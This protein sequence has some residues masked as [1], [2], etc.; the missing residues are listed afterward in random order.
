MTIVASCCLI[1]RIFHFLRMYETK[2]TLLVPLRWAYPPVFRLLLPSGFCFPVWL[3]LRR[4]SYGLCLRLSVLA[5]RSGPVWRGQ[6]APAGLIWA[7]VAFCTRRPPAQG[8]S[9]AVRQL[10]HYPSGSS[11]GRFCVIFS[12][13]KGLS[14]VLTIGEAFLWFVF[15]FDCRPPSLSPFGGHGLRRLHGPSA[16]RH[17]IVVLETHVTVVFQSEHVVLGIDFVVWAWLHQNCSAPS[18]PAFALFLSLF[19]RVRHVC[20]CTSWST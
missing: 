1:L 8:F 4:Y 2:C 10:P 11:I 7:I 20:R 15:A 14:S 6:A 17:A 18:V 19:H 5:R 12:A 9:G 16:P 3:I 13:R